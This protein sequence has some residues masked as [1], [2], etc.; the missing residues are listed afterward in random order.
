M[1]RSIKHIR[2]RLQVLDKGNSAF[3]NKTQCT[4]VFSLYISGIENQKVIVDI[5]NL[6]KT[7]VN[8]LDGQVTFELYRP[9]Q[10]FKGA[11]SYRFSQRLLTLM[12]NNS[13]LKA[14]IN[15]FFFLLR[16]QTS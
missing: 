15:F 11:V 4:G 14:D 12:S 2:N 16:R 1:P 10:M 3:I 13:E 5:Q 6:R 8:R 7:L 9:C